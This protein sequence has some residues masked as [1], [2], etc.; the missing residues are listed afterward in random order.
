VIGREKPLF[1]LLSS[2]VLYGIS[3]DGRF[4]IGRLAEPEPR[5][6]IRVVLNWFDELKKAG[7][8]K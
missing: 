3:P 6:G 7:S 2:S 8:G 5:P 4:L 1:P